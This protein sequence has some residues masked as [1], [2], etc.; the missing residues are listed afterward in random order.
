[1][2]GYEPVCTGE[3]TCTKCGETK[4]VLA[5]SAYPYCLDGLS[6]WCRDCANECSSKSKS[7]KRSRKKQKDYAFGA[8]RSFIRRG[9]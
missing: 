5:F 4:H 1:M 8:S 3:K 7:K 2:A 6:S 9:Y